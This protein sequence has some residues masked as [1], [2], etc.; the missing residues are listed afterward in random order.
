MQPIF[1]YIDGIENAT[2]RGLMYETHELI[3]HLLP[4]VLPTIKW[5]IPCYDYYGSYFC[6]L[7]TYK[8][9]MYISL[10]NKKEHLFSE[11]LYIEHLKIASKVYIP[12]RNVLRSDALAELIIHAAVL[13]EA[14]FKK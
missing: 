11:S 7:N 6:Y 12:D 13:H 4:E 3:T 2:V 1:R 10:V 14:M 5:R 8:D 9:H